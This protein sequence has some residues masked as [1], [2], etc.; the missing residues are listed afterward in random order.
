MIPD[1]SRRVP[2]GAGA[3]LGDHERII[4]NIIF[5]AYSEAAGWREAEPRIILGV[6]QH[7]DRVKTLVPAPLQARANQGGTDALPSV[8]GINPQGRKAHDL[9]I[10]SSRQ[11]Y[12]SEQN[13]PDNRAAA[14]RDQGDDGFGFPA[15]RADKIGL[16][17]PLKRGDMNCVDRSPIRILFGSNSHPSSLNPQLNATVCLQNEPRHTHYYVDSLRFLHHNAHCHRQQ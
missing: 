14:F 8:T 13:V 11:D 5:A 10:R 6:P 2:K 3:K 4:R 15:K 7:D 9:E 1:D 16:G 12:G 17:T